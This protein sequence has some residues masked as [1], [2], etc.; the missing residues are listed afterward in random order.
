MTLGDIIKIYVVDHSMNDFLKN[1][2]LSKAYTYLLIK[3]KNHVGSDI[4]PSL[5]TIKRVAA[6]VEKPF[7]EV[8]NSLDMDMEIHLESK[9]PTGEEAERYAAYID[10]LLFEKIKVMKPTT[11]EI[12]LIEKM[13]KIDP[14]Y[15]PLV[16]SVIDT[17]Y[18]IS[19]GEKDGKN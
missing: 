4:K 10:A 2:G 9:K 14:D 13:R 12:A 16:L 19:K 15:M 17:A 5:D 7:D 3:G 18:D 1:S 6:G 11:E 8:F